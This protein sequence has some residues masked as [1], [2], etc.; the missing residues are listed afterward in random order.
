LRVD[1]GSRVNRHA[2]ALDGRDGDRRFGNYF[3]GLRRTVGQL[4]H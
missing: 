2:M 3:A 1:D 4:A